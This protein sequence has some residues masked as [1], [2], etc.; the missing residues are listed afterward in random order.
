MPKKFMSFSEKKRVDEF[1]KTVLTVVDADDDMALQTVMY[2]G[3]WN[4][5]SVAGHLGG[6]ATGPSVRNIR[7][8]W[9]GQTVR[10]AKN[11]ADLAEAVIEK[12]IALSERRLENQF[13]AV[14]K[15]SLER[16]N[17]LEARIAVLEGG[18]EI[19]DFPSLP[20]SGAN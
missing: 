19:G 13:H 11:G 5:R 16:I 8:E 14:Q 17:G 2:D 12:A 15:A 4:D 9:H 18:K 20:L 3:D 10:R 1:L 7:I 6:K